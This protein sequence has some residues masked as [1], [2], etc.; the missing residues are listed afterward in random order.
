MARILTAALVVMGITSGGGPNIVNAF[1]AASPADSAAQTA[2]SIGQAIGAAAA[3]PDISRTRIKAVADSLQDAIRQFTNDKQTALAIQDSYDQGVTFGQK[4]ISTRQTDCSAAARDIAVWDRPRLQ[5]ITVAASM[6]PAPAMAGAAP[7]PTPVVASPAPALVERALDVH[8]ITDQEIRLGMAAPL[9]GPSKDLGREMKIGIEI[10]FDTVNENGGI[11]GRKLTLVAMDDGYEP[12]RTGAVMK[13]LYEKENVFGFTG[14]VGTPT[15]A[16]ALPFA[17]SNDALFFGAF[18]GAPLLRR[19]P[20]DRLVFNFRAS[21]AEETS[22]VVRYLVK[23]RRL[24]P[25][26]VAVFA[27]QDGFGDAGFDGVTKAVRGLTTDHSPPT[28][29]RLGYERNTVDVDAAVNQLMQHNSQKGVLPIKAVVMVATYRAAARFIDKTHDQL[30][31]LIYTNVS[32]VGSTSLAEELK[33][34]GAKYAAG[35]I[36]TQV[37]P[38]VEGYSTIV[39]KYKDALA[40]YFPGEPRDYV[41][42]EGYLQ[43]TLLIEGIRRAGPELTTDKLVDALEAIHGFDAGVGTAVNFSSM[44]HQALHKV[45]GTQL[46]NDAH[47]QPIDLE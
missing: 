3:C 41:S 7:A 8:G 15:T 24:R 33:V 29:L 42:F 32:F 23:V 25:E 43:A 47:Y 34:L 37:V 6:P 28:I 11:N 46:D 20:P 35:V 19:D 13:Q 4:A 40:K 31:G 16:V 1:A 2:L 5:L 22:T 36:V 39:L 10:A 26:Q 9:S 12:S 30:P 27:Q 21:Y 38:P 14:N 45:W 44:D 18:T 17:L